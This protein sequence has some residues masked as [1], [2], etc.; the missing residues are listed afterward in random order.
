[1]ISVKEFTS[2]GELT[3]HPFYKSQWGITYTVF[4]DPTKIYEYLLQK[5]GQDIGWAVVTETLPHFC[6]DY[7]HKPIYSV[8]KLLAT[9]VIKEEHRKQGWG[10]ILLDRVKNDHTPLLLDSFKNE[11]CLWFYKMGAN[12]LSDE[13]YEGGQYM[14]FG[15]DEETR[16]IFYEF[17]DD[18]DYPTIAYDNQMRLINALPHTLCDKK[19]HVANMCWCEDD[20]EHLEF[21]RV[22]DDGT[23]IFV[24]SYGEMR[25]EMSQ[26]DL[27][28]Q[29]PPAIW[30]KLLTTPRTLLN[31]VDENIEYGIQ[32]TDT[33][34]AFFVQGSGIYFHF[35]VPLEHCHDA[36]K[37]A[38]DMINMKWAKS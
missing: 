11:T 32:S 8:S 5:D 9:F 17:N 4:K 37:S 19:I 21:E 29:Y 33:H 36:I 31:F 10:K 30:N 25:F 35:E 22:S 2:F 24:F 20:S 3:Y 1:M 28:T 38:Y 12:Y 18:I 26:G 13:I 27:Y 7:N 14:V 23:H 16:K 15:T 34:L 6:E